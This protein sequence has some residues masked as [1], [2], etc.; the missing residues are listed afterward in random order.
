MPI[1]IDPEDI[2]A[3][4]P[5]IAVLAGQ[6]ELE[7]ESTLAASSGLQQ[8]LHIGGIDALTRVLVRETAQLTA[9]VSRAT[10]IE[11]STAAAE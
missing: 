4:V 6:L 11:P 2:S 8:L 9:A 3:H 1:E 7:A 5:L 10:G